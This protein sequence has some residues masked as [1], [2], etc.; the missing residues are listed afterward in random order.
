M[1]TKWLLLLSLVVILSSHIVDSQ[2]TTYDQ[3]CG[4]STGKP[5]VTLQRILDNQQQLFQM[6][7]HQQQQLQTLENRLGK[8][9]G[10]IV[11]YSPVI[12]VYQK[13]WSSQTIR[14]SYSDWP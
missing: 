3:V 5:D 1:T 4:R 10:K 13:N 6:L 11:A 8:L 7:N 2:S 9:Y 12:S 14:I